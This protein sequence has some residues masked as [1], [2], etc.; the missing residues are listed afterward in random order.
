M[1]S[2]G[3]GA[4]ARSPRWESGWAFS[5]GQQRRR[6]ASRGCLTGQQSLPTL[7]IAGAG[8]LMVL[9]IRALRG[10]PGTRS[11]VPTRVPHRGIWPGGALRQGALGNL[12][13]P[14]AGV[15]FLSIFP[16]FVSPG[17]SPFRLLTMLVVF[18][19]MIVT[20]LVC[21]GSVVSKS[22]EDGLAG[23]RSTPW[24]EL[25]APC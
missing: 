7:K 10:S 23:R 18:A 19:A 14:K 21:Y 1:C 8:Y 22:A 25:L 15:I 11:T 16:Q 24:S 13:N 17:D 6:S 4:R 3:A 5:A 12:L 20:W 9:G 2:Q